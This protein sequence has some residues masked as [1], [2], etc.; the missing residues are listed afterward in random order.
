MR[1][2]KESDDSQGVGLGDQKDGV[3]SEEMARPRVEQ[4]LRGR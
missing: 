3:T 2:V 4:V 1:D